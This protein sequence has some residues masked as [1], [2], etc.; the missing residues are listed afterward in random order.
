MQFILDRVKPL[1]ARFE[2]L[3]LLA[4]RAAKVVTPHGHA[5]SV[6]TY[7]ITELFEDRIFSV[8]A[9]VTFF[10]LLALF[11]AVACIVSIYGIFGDRASISQGLL[12]SSGFLPG[13]ATTVLQA[14]L[15]RLLSG[16]PEKL[17]V[18]VLTGFVIA[19]WSA[20]GGVRALMDGLNV[21]FE[22][23]ESR[24]LL[25][26][27]VH[28]VAITCA[29]IVFAALGIALDDRLLSLISHMP[30]G[31]II[32][33]GLAIITWL[34]VFVGCVFL[35]SLIYHYGPDRAHTPWR[36]I[37][38]GGT[39]AAIVWIGGTLLFTW[40]VKNFGHYDE[41]YGNLGAAVG[42]LT[43]IWLSMVVLLFGAEIDCEIERS[44]RSRN[45]A[46]S[47]SRRRDG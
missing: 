5:W 42:F 27:T 13:G 37:T 39:V 9:G 23:R 34:V 25:R 33:I 35:A 18:G 45:P 43:W 1:E 24:G 41:M 32:D 22:I 11:P 2:R 40:F 36:W 44:S 46:S 15:A 20:S 28:A 47:T 17:S 19:I 6:A 21:A 38:W 12:S 4:N 10:L 16:A 26:F 29:G 7:A 8:A 30:H 3:W 14:Q 31:A